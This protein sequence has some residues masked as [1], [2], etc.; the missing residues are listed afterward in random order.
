MGLLSN[1]EK[2]EEEMLLNPSKIDEIQ[3]RRDD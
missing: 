3:K 1:Q 2:D